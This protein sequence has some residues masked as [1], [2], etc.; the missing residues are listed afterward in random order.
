MIVLAITLHSPLFQSFALCSKQ[1]ENPIDDPMQLEN[2][3]DDPMQLENPIDVPMQLENPIDDP[4][5]LENPIDVP[6][7]RTAKPRYTPP[8]ATIISSPR[9]R[10]YRECRYKSKQNRTIDKESGLSC[11]AC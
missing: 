2:P 8:S 3:I 9:R 11:P 1:L 7:L 4:M 5:Q 10:Y 6:I